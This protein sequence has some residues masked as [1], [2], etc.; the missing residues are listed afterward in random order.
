MS[1]AT[2]RTLDDAIGDVD[3][4]AIAPGV[5]IVR[6]TT[7][8]GE[9]AGHA[10]GD[11]AHPRIVLIPGVTGSKEDFALMSPLLVRA[12]YRVEG[13]DLAGQYQSHEAGPER[14]DPPPQALRP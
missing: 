9:L 4:A 1:A 10:V 3:W 13:F 8:S 11:P 14:L 12:G 2:A 5:E 7:P 6:Y